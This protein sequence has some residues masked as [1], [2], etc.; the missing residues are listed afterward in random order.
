MIM[1][2]QIVANPS[3]PFSHF[4][5]L[6]FPFSQFASSRHGYQNRTIAYFAEFDLCREVHASDLFRLSDHSTEDH[7]FGTGNGAAAGGPMDGHK[8]LARLKKNTFSNQNHQCIHLLIFQVC[9]CLGDRCNVQTNGVSSNIHVIPS[10]SL[11]ILLLLLLLLSAPS[12]FLNSPLLFN[13]L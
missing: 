2:W 11:S 12:I 9:S 13:P 8:I 5:L 10:S 6:I 1:I 7:Y 4:L 3:G